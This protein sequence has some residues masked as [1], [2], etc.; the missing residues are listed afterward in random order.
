[1][2]SVAAAFVRGSEK[3]PSVR[4]KVSF[5]QKKEGVLVCARIR[6]LPK[7]SSFLGF[8]IH[9]GGFCSGS[10]QDPFADALGHYNPSAKLHPFHAG[11]LPPLLVNGQSAYLSFVTGRFAVPEILGRAVIIHSAPDDFTTQPSGAS[12][13]RIACGVIRKM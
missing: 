4:G 3:Y 5:V 10:A 7:G 6:G 2:T 8:H 13:E 9:S 11:D 12:G 1:M